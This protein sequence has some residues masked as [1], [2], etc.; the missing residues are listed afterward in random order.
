MLL[1]LY[2][3]PP[4]ASAQFGPQAAQVPNNFI[5]IAPDGTV[6]IMAK[7]PEVGQGV[8]TMLPMLIAEELDVDWKT[9]K[10]EQADFDDTKYARA[11]RRR[12]HGDAVE[13]G[14]HA[15]RGRGR[16]PVAGVARRRRP[17]ACRN[18]NAPRLRAACFTP[19]RTR[20]VGYG[21]IAGKAA[22]MPPPDLQKVK[23]KDPKD[24]KIIGH[25][26]RGYDVPKIVTG[27]PIFAIDFTLPGMLFAVYQ[28]CPVF[29]GKVV[30][31][32]L[33]EI[34]AMPGVRDAFVVEGNVK[35]GMIVE[36]GRAWSLASPSSPIAG[37][38]RRRRARSCR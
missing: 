38:R 2:I 35:P 37:G 13:L 3:K 17:G 30:S 29:G 1:G 32:N 6:T 33:D 26:Q 24:Y 21:E 27:K 25:S 16:P 18:R 10:I 22:T 36:A 8:K 11:D 23:L 5:K 9:V 34:K 12:Q 19:D 4:K 20:S 15:A 7:N 28:K 14:P 31:A